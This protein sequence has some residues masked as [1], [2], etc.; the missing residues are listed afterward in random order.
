M[1]NVDFVTGLLTDNEGTSAMQ[2]SYADR[3]RLSAL[4]KQVTHGKYTSDI[5]PSVGLLD[6][7]GN[8]Q[9]YFTLL[10]FSYLV[11]ASYK[12]NNCPLAYYIFTTLFYTVF[13]CSSKHKALTWCLSVCTCLFYP[14]SLDTETYSPR[15]LPDLAI[16]P[17]HLSV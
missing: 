8:D 3:L 9:R 4:T 10:Y 1:I 2:I 11:Y 14:I 7:F 12:K 15:A 17:F 16:T 13:V 6:V 5:A